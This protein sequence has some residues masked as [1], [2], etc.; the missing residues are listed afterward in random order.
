MKME[1]WADGAKR[2][3]LFANYLC[4]RERV[5]LVMVG[6]CVNADIINCR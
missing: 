5:G 1:S 3:K 2:R 4:I 6:L